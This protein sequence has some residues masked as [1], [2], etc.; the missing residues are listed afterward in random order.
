MLK[1]NFSGKNKQLKLYKHL[2]EKTPLE[3]CP[4]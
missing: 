3:R 1:K 4:L 2:F